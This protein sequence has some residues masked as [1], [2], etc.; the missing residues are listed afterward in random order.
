MPS[1]SE[2]TFKLSGTEALINLTLLASEAN[3]V[4]LVGEVR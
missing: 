3:H 2:I 1:T 4:L